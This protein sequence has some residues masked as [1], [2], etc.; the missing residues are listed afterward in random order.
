MVYCK[1]NTIFLYEGDT[2]VLDL[3]IVGEF[4]DGD[5]LEFR[6]KENMDDEECLYIQKVSK[7]S[8]GRFGVNIDKK[9]SS[10]LSNDTDM[11]KTFYYGFKL[12]KQDENVDTIIAKGKIVVMKGV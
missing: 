6:V 2:G 4:N 9:V 12:R 3:E 8:N 11:N 7:L 5:S 1:D 10:I